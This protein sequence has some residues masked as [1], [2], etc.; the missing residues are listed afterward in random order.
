APGRKGVA[1]TVP[2][3][4]EHRRPRPAP[5]PEEVAV[6][7]VRQASGRHGA[8][9]RVQG[10]RSDLAA[11]KRTWLAGNRAGSVQVLLDVLQ[12]KQVENGRHVF[13]QSASLPGRD[14]RSRLWQG[15]IG[16]VDQAGENPESP[17]A[18][19]ALARTARRSSCS[20]VRHYR[21]WF[22]TWPPA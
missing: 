21:E 17:G 5:L 13:Q 22:L 4:P 7:R 8:P 10:L 1:V 15:A 19:P 9:S 11:V 12:V 6:Q 2:V 18:A 20:L 16:R 14:E 3:D